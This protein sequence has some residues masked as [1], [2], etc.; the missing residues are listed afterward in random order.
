[1]AHFIPSKDLVDLLDTHMVQ[2]DKEV[3]DFLNSITP[4]A[5]AEE[6]RQNL[7]KAITEEIE[8][9]LICIA[10]DMG[11]DD[12]ISITEGG[13]FTPEICKQIIYRL[14]LD[15][16]DLS[17]VFDRLYAELTYFCI[18]EYKLIWCKAYLNPKGDIIIE[19]SKS[20]FTL[21]DFDEIINDGSSWTKC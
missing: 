2:P 4:L 10:Q 7:A 13:R 15:P 3:M 12:T 19:S 1:M 11:K 6:Y 5:C 9:M 21:P 20:I 18:L 8:G 17:S 16:Y 14:G